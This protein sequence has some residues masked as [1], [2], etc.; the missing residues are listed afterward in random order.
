MPLRSSSQLLPFFPT[1][2]PSPQLLTSHPNPP[3]AHLLFNPKKSH[4]IRRECNR[5]E[6]GKDIKILLELNRLSGKKAFD[7]ALYLLANRHEYGDNHSYRDNVN[8]YRV[9]AEDVS[10]I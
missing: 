10:D 1:P 7:G 8:K 9:L 6:G 4:G 3:S 5:V 2:S